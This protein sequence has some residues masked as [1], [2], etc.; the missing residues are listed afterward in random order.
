MATFPLFLP[1]GVFQV[2]VS[3]LFLL[4]VKW[5]SGV[6]IPFPGKKQEAGCDYPLFSMDP[7]EGGS[8][9]P[10]RMV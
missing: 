7:K 10:K 2:E 5:V 6:G 3:E 4:G 9:Q 8:A 1:D